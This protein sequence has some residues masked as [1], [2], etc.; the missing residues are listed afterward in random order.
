MVDEV[1][2]KAWNMYLKDNKAYGTTY[3]SWWE[4]PEPTQNHYI[5]KVLVQEFSA[6][7]EKEQ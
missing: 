1:Q 3:Q 2:Y 4:L 5:N 7:E 6:K